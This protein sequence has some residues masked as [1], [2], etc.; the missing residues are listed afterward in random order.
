[1]SK[2]HDLKRLGPAG[3]YHRIS[4]SK[5][6]MLLEIYGQKL[7]VLYMGGGEIQDNKIGRT[8]ALL[9]QI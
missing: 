6:N 9:N 1:M 4:A 7:F 5:Y 2:L 8:E 3:S